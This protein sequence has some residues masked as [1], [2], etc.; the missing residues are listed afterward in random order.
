MTSEAVERSL[1]DAE[2]LL[3]G[4]GPEHA[5]D[6]VHTA[7]H[8]YLRAALEREGASASQTASPTELFKSLREAHPN[9]QG[10]GVRGADSRRI[11]SAL[12]TILDALGTLRNQASGAHPNPAVLEPAEAMLAIN[13][14]RS[15]I[16]YLDE[17]LR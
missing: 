14:A 2:L 17:R 9:L 4:R 11:L 7:V 3:R 13:A 10:L 6:R 15:L 16:H 1:A 12:A 8:G 5:F